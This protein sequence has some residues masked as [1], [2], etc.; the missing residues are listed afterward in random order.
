MSYHVVRF[1]KR[2][3][4]AFCNIKINFIMNIPDYP[5]QP[6]SL[7]Q[8]LLWIC[9]KTISNHLQIKVL[10]DDRNFVS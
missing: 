1:D 7:L 3:Y 5:D 4:M 9:D 8:H 10:T 6:A 2:H